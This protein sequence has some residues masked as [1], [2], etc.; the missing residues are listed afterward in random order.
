MDTCFAGDTSV[1]T[2]TGLKAIESIVVG[3]VVKSWN[4]NTNLFE[5]KRVTQVF[6]HEVPQLFFLELDG[7]EEI[8]VTW[9]HPFRRRTPS[10]SGEV[11]T[12]NAVSSSELLG[13]S[14]YELLGV[15]LLDVSVSSGGSSDTNNNLLVLGEKDQEN[16]VLQTLTT[17]QLA[18]NISKAQTLTPPLTTRSEW[19]KVEDLRL[20]DQ[21]LKSDGSWGTVTG[22]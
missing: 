3:D 21:V 7:E 1:R 18:T 5:N 22:V 16:S 6:V 19:V 15:S 17:N 14:A 8:H 2:E 11:S 10:E 13:V 9:N 12:A 20:K 4:E